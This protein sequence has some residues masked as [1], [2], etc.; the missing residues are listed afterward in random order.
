MLFRLNPC[1]NDTV[2]PDAGYKCVSPEEMKKQYL[3]STLTIATLNTYF[4]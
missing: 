4:N 1:S 2:P 3:V